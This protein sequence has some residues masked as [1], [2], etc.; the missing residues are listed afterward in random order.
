MAA[1]QPPPC[2]YPTVTISGALSLT[3][4]PGTTLPPPLLGVSPLN[5]I[6]TRPLEGPH[7]QVQSEVGQ[8]V[9]A[10]TDIEDAIFL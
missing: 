5:S 2:P 9:P 10:R 4:A 7:T 1:G 8:G 6:Y 3:S